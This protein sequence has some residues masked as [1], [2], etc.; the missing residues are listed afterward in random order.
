ME[1]I[2]GLISALLWPVLIILGIIWL[3]RKLS[4]PSSTQ[5]NI[6]Q[7]TSINNPAQPSEWEIRNKVAG[8]IRAQGTQYKTAGQKQVVE[9]M[10]QTVEYFA[11]HNYVQ[12]PAD[13]QPVV[14]YSQEIHQQALATS[15]VP[16]IAET[17]VE[18]ETPWKK[19]QLLD[20]VTILLYL[21]AFLLLA[22][23][24]LYVGF[25]TGAR[26]KAVLVL[27]LTIVFYFAGLQLYERTKRLRPAGLTF[28]AIGMAALP[29]GGAA[30]YF[31]AFNKTHG[32]AVWL[33]TS[34]IGLLM[35]IVAL[36]KLKSP[37][38]S[39]VVVFSSLSVVLSSISALGLAPFYFIQ[40]LGI[41]GLV[42]LFVSQLITSNE[43]GVKEAYEQ[44][45][46]FFV[47][48]SIGMSVLFVVK[49]GWLQLALSLLVGALYYAY[50]AYIAT[51]KKSLYILLAQL[52]FIPGIIT[53]AYALA[54]NS[55]VVRVLLCIVVG[56]YVL[57]W[58][59]WARTRPEVDVYRRQVKGLLLSLPLVAT[60]TFMITPHALWVGIVV[61]TLAGMIVYNTDRDVLSGTEWTA[62]LLL[63]PVTV[64]I[65]ALTPNMDM[66]IIGLL[67]VAIAVAA[68][69]I[70]I[71]LRSY[72]SNTDRLLQ[73]AVL[74]IAI[75]AGALF[76]IGATNSTQAIVTITEVILLTLES[77]FESNSRVWFSLSATLY[78]VWLIAYLDNQKLLVAMLS[79]FLVYNLVIAQL[80]V[81]GMIH[82]WYAC[83]S[84]LALPVIY[85]LVARDIKWGSKELWIAYTGLALLFILVRAS[86]RIVTPASAVFGY[87][88]SIVIAMAF[89]YSVSPSYGMWTAFGATG[90]LLFCEWLEKSDVFGYIAPLLPLTLL[91]DL[92]SS[93]KLTLL[94]VSLVTSLTII[95]TII[96]RRGYEAYLS[97]IGVLLLP[98]YAGT[99]VYGWP[100]YWL[101]GAYLGL[102]GVLI[103]S[104]QLLKSTSW[105]S[106]FKTVCIVGYA[107][108]LIA[109][110]IYGGLGGWKVA[111]LSY[112]VS[113]LL[114][115]AISYVEGSPIVIIMAFISG[116]I[117]ILRY[118]TG[119]ELSI[120]QTVALLLVLTQGIYWLLVFSKLKTARAGYARVFQVCVGLIIP[121]VGVGYPTKSI[122]PLALAL[123]GGMLLNEI[124]Q[125]GQG[126]REAALLVIHTSLLWWL[127][128]IGVK[129]FQIYSQS[130]AAVIG[131]FAY[132]RRTLKDTPTVINQYLWVAV[133]IFSLPMAWQAIASGNITYA[134]LVL[135]EHVALILISIAFKRATFAWWGIAVVVASVMYQLR[136]LRYAALAFLGVFI[137]S[138]AVYFLLR[139]NKPDQSQK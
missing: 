85:G 47:P 90:L 65:L 114:L 56:V 53:G 23:I 60:A 108:A 109:G 19:L 133:L 88:A 76:Q 67:Y 110:A 99:I 1:I 64:G 10:A 129:E 127:Y 70:G 35:Y 5:Y 22:S 9:E 54:A 41:S 116:Y 82:S 48:F 51:S 62:S 15:T 33:T 134:Y 58:L 4:R 131:L 17:R 66:S 52:M 80:K 86:R 138:L 102:S 31:Y 126:Q 122:F 81:T 117:A 2:L 100:N 125:K 93:A 83:L 130:T 139:Y 79:G 73:R 115:T 112:F 12:Q 32:A 75:I 20:S 8:E 3:V 89:A 61:T 103:L 120:N 45:S 24:G 18:Y 21:G 84:L 119:L 68:V 111:A 36:Q 87:A 135:T 137:I 101:C 14:E 92:N 39:Y 121:L 98:W 55:I 63:L 74:A 16:D 124:W 50:S 118:T 132:W 94:M 28:V 71:S 26:I 128:D 40:G 37:L 29:M 59:M 7:S 43:T 46:V 30:T 136:R 72:L 113:G 6:I 57:I 95:L 96:R 104:R 42:F 13:A 106:T 27:L 34:L 105:S 91:F 97:V 44:S 25:G 49:V 123:F 11:S 77:W 78:A 69:L 107:P 38:I